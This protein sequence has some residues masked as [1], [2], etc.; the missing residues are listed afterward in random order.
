MATKGTIS[1]PLDIDPNRDVQMNFGCPFCTTD[2]QPT[3][4]RHLGRKRVMKGIVRNSYWCP[5][6]GSSV[7]LY[8][9]GEM[10]C[11]RPKYLAKVAEVADLNLPPDQDFAQAAF[12]DATFHVD[13]PG[14]RTPEITLMKVTKK[15]LYQ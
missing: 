14:L 12:V 1:I 8:Q 4:L 10:Q 2:N 7:D 6:C 3:R 15:E 11:H 5:N 9:D 13:K